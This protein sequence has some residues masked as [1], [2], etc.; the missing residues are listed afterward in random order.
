MRGARPSVS[1]HEPPRSWELQR[2]RRGSPTAALGCQEAGGRGQDR[3]PWGP[4]PGEN[5]STVGDATSSV[6]PSSLSCGWDS[7]S[8]L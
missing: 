7:S 4:R 2:Q 1:A 5:V 6:R 8:E 3:D